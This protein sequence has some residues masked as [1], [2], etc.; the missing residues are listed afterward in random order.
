MKKFP[1]PFIVKIVDDFIDSQDHQCIVQEIYDQGDFNKFLNE[2]KGKLFKEDEVIHFLANII[3]VVHHLNCRG[4][5]H[6]DLKPENFFLNSYSNGNI[7]LHLSDFGFAKHT[8]PDYF[9]LSS[10][11]CSL[12]G[13]LEY[14]APEFLQEEFKEKPDIS[15]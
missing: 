13:T 8:H 14:L 10:V 12:K 7:F 6:R 4:I 2:R 15:K 5:Y 3:I 1:H 9:R 11:Y